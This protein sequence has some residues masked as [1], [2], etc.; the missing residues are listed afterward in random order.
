MRRAVVFDT[1]ILSALCRTGNIPIDALECDAWVKDLKINHWE[2]VLPGLADYEVRRELLRAKK[3]NSLTMLNHLKLTH[4]F[5]AIEDQHMLLAA[6][7][8]ANAR[9]NRLG[10]ADPKALDGDVILC[11]QALSI[12]P[13]Y[14]SVIVATNNVSHISRYCNAA[15]WRNIAP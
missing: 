10:T 12:A 7:L 1:G 2:V 6:T 11:A 13:N 9:N 4:K 14:A 15:E 5:L 3:I 8:W